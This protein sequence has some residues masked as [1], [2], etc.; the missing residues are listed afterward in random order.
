MIKRYIEYTAKNV[1]YKIHIEIDTF[2]F[3]LPF[4]L[5]I[6]NIIFLNLIKIIIL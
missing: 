4:S 2:P 3:Y 5:H 1:K 6:F